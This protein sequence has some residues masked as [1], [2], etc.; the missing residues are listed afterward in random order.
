MAQTV[1][2]VYQQSLGL[3]RGRVNQLYGRNLEL[4][5]QEMRNRREQ[6]A[7]NAEA[8]GILRSGETD[9]ANKRLNEE[10]KFKKR[11]LAEDKAYQL[12]GLAMDE[13]SRAAQKAAAAASGSGGSSGM[14]ASSA[15]TAEQYLAQMLNQAGFR[16]NPLPVMSPQ[17]R[18][19]VTAS[20][21][22]SRTPSFTAPRP[23]T[24]ST[25]RYRL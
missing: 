23:A 6:L 16:V 22:G 1:E 24:V 12:Q 25:T 20:G 14:P 21:M 10:E 18:T 17:Q 13:A 8:R 7:S 2:Q 5:A 4:L 3:E 15:M 19:A 11:T 9:L